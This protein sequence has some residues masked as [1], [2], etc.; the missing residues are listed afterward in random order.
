MS[1]QRIVK[2]LTLLALLVSY[3][4]QAALYAA[5]GVVRQQEQS[6]PP[7]AGGRHWF[8]E[9]AEGNPLPLHTDAEV[10]DFLLTAPVISS[11]DIGKGVTGALQLLLQKDGLSV[12]AIF[13]DVRDVRPRESR[14]GRKVPLRDDFIFERAAYDLSR[15][16]GLDN[17]PPVVERE[18]DGKEGTLQIWIEG[19][20]TE[21]ERRERGVF[22]SD[23][24]RLELQWQV[25]LIFDNLIFND[26]RNRGNFLY[27][28]NG[29][30]WMIDHTRSFRQDDE[31]PYPTAIRFCERNLWKNL[32]KLTHSGIAARL[33][34]YLNA[35]ELKSLIQRKEKLVEHVEQ[36]IAERGE[37]DVL[38][39]F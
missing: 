39:S 31:L 9:D 37:K 20:V 1:V 12:H 11:R 2:Q 14:T 29:K 22:Q 19:A 32:R 5:G 38:F 27:D 18:V 15:L 25:M 23:E 24:Q 8:L 33:E 36:M 34:K 3:P 35:V 26:D 17:V 6:V 13:R 10:V 4:D 16:L 7:E 28:R 21:K 30:L